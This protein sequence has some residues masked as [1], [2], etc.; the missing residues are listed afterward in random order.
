M[1]FILIVYGV[2]CRV[3][4][5]N[6]C[7]YMPLSAGK[8]VATTVTTTVDLTKNEIFTAKTTF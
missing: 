4:M 3:L 2:G 1:V 5:A 6:W 7:K 8:G